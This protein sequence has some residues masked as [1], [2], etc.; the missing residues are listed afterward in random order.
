MLA[1][2]YREPGP[3]DRPDSLLDVE[4]DDPAPG[5]KDL[6]VEVAAIAVNPVDTKIRASR[7][8]QPG[9]VEVLGWDA[10][11]TVVGMGDEVTGFSAGD[12]VYYAGAINRPGC[13]SQLHVV[14]HRIAA[15]A[16][17]SLTDAEAAALPLTSI[18]AWEL[19]FDRLGVPR[20]GG[21]GQSLLIIGAAGGVGSVLTQL[22]RTQTQLTVI[23]TASRPETAQWVRDLGA[24][25]VLNH[26]EPWLPQLTEA[27]VG[28]VTY[29]ACL[30]HTED[31]WPSVVEV[32]APQG[33]IG[34]IDD[35]SVPLDTNALKGKSLSLRWELMFTRSLFET[36]D[37]ADQGALLAEVAGLVD[38][39]VLRTTLQDAVSP[40][41]A[42][43]LI[44]AHQLLESGRAVGKLVLTGW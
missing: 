32:A 7:A 26:H 25:H 44:A 11:G 12:R 39:G 18:T 4:L 28:Q 3:V 22:A 27:G 24:H 21:L 15:A 23:G 36:P 5:P 40:I 14:D 43:N 30:T 41:N 20:G 31:H 19:L 1:V 9:G 34:I 35:P 17:T 37:I 29:Q 16:P 6:L 38:S 8:P 33:A 10:V 42:A 2:G 13:D